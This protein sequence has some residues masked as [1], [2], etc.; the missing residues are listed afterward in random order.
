MEQLCPLECPK[1]DGLR[2][3][4]EGRSSAVVFRLIAFETDEAASFHRSDS[5]ADDACRWIEASSQPVIY[6]SGQSGVGKSSLVNAAIAPSPT[7]IHGGMRR[8]AIGREKGLTQEQVEGTQPAV[9]QRVG[10]GTA[11]P[12]GGHAV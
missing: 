4:A 2:Q 1:V 6:L 5:S 9:H 7:S 10:A 8:A 3:I 12:D 11:Q